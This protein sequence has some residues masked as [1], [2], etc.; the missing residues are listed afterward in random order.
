MVV[1]AP[2]YQEKLLAE[3]ERTTELSCPLSEPSS[4]PTTV[5]Q[6]PKEIGKLIVCVPPR[7][8]DLFAPH[9]LFA[10]GYVLDIRGVIIVNFKGRFGGN[11]T[12]KRIAHIIRMLVR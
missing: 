11:I 8:Q 6:V 1:V 2:E 3:K 10:Y 5:K 12:A 9:C 4:C 7:V